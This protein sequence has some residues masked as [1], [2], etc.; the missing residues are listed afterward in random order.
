MHCL[1]PNG[2]KKVAMPP[3]MPLPPS[4]PVP[5]PPSTASAAAAV[6]QKEED[7]TE[8]LYQATFALRCNPTGQNQAAGTD[9]HGVS[10]GGCVGVFDEFRHASC[11]ATDALGPEGA[12]RALSKILQRCKDLDRPLYGC[13][14]TTERGLKVPSLAELEEL[15]K[16]LEELRKTSLRNGLLA[17]LEELRKK[18]AQQSQ[19]MQR[20]LDVPTHE[21]DSHEAYLHRCMILSVKRQL[22]ERSQELINATKDMI[23]ELR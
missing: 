16:K 6:S 2:E 13:P 14:E 22:E 18:Q 4:P 3:A 8:R 1:P 11:A 17:E 12:W 10:P 7:T 15:R 9:G 5:S 23:E 20:L 19:K 21:Q